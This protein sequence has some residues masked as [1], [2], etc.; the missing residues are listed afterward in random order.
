MQDMIERH[1]QAADKA[2]GSV[3]RAMGISPVTVVDQLSA[4]HAMTPR[5]FDLIAKTYGMNQAL[6][7]IARMEAMR[8]GA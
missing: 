6:G 7:Y 4:Y 1:K 8:S 5:D 3:G 2:L